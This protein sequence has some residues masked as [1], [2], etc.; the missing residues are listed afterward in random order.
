MTIQQLD[1]LQ[2]KFYII[3]D[4]GATLGRQADNSIAV[5][6]EYISRFHAQIIFHQNTFY[7]RDLGSQCG[8]FIRIDQKM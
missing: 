8:T 4:N 7:I 2:A 6:D 1:Q 5:I 3:D